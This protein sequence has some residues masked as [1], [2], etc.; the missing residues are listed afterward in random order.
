MELRVMDGPDGDEA[1][2]PRPLITTA[3]ADIAHWSEAWGVPPERLRETVRRYGP[4]ITAVAR[5]L[6]REAEV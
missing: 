6:D 1:R 5:A 4:S 2:P 3:D